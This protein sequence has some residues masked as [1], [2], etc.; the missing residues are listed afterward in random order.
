MIFTHPLVSAQ[1]DHHRHLARTSSQRLVRSPQQQRQRTGTGAIRHHQA[2]PL[3][4]QVGGT[5]LSEDE[6]A[7]LISL[8]MRPNPTDHG[9]LPGATRFA[10]HVWVSMRAG[11]SGDGHDATFLP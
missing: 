10:A 3:A 8:Q 4:V 6:I 1:R 11:I 9:C 7:D 5:Q 2:D